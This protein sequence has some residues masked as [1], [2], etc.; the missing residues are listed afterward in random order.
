[1][2]TCYDKWGKRGF[3]NNFIIKEFDSCTTNTLVDG[4]YIFKDVNFPQ[5]DENLETEIRWDYPL[6]SL[7][8]GR[9]MFSYCKN[10]TLFTPDLLELTNGA[11]M[12][13]YCSNL[14]SFNSKLTTPTSCEGMFRG[15]S[16]LKEID[17]G[18]SLINCTNCRFMFEKCK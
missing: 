16:K 3:S 15:C 8:I 5:Y 17:L 12:F 10:L 7:K 11:Y 18:E 9:G 13:S 6:S 14:E 1:M 2:K 4:S